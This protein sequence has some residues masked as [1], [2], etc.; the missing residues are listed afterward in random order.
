MGKLDGSS[1]GPYERSTRSKVESLVSGDETPQPPP[2][3]A[4][5]ITPQLL[6]C[7]KQFIF[8]KARE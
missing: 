8:W 2:S 5:L 1:D 4:F 3:S 7:Q 6:R